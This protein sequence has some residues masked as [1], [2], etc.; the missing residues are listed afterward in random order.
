MKGAIAAIVVKDLRL[1]VRDRATLFFTILFPI[2][3]AVL[4]GTVFGRSPN[5]G[6]LEISVAIE[7]DGPLARSFAAALES[8]SSLLVFA[9]SDRES[10]IALVRR[11]KVSAAVIIPDGFDSRAATIFSGGAMPIE[12]VGDPS[13][14]A[15]VGL[16]EGKLMELGFR[17]L[18]KIVADP[19]Q[20]KR[21]EQTLKDQLDGDSSISPRVRRSLMKLLAA[22]GELSAER[23]DS[24]GAAESSGAATVKQAANE[25]DGGAFESFRPIRINREMLSQEPR[26]GGDPP[27]SYAVTFPQGVVWGL[28]GCVMAFV[29]TLVAERAQGTLT[30]LRA[31]PLSMRLILVGKGLVCVISSMAMQSLLLA[32]AWGVFAV[33]PVDPLMLLV[34]MFV[35]SVTFTS[36]AMMIAAL[37]RTGGGAEGAGRAIVLVMALIGG[38]SI[39]LVFMPPVMRSLSVVSP[40]RWAIAAI[41]GPLWRGGPIGDQFVAIGAVAIVGVL[42]GSIALVAIARPRS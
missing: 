27:S 40:F 33:K 30:R 39:P 1:L 19:V 12:L 3:I 4:F 18:M 7:D 32:L 23:A 5:A 13:A 34:A 21:Q 20:L 14:P 36:L 38:G 16:L 29:T 28:A 35:I 25:S 24:T 15:E 6:M 10:A 2:I 8:D 41:E 17:Q 31:A 42:C 9:T 26:G 22:T 11:G 37:F